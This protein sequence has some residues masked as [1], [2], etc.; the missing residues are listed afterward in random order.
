MPPE[1]GVMAVVRIWENREQKGQ[2]V[3]D[4]AGTIGACH[5]AGSIATELW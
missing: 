5:H 1:M 4:T 2:L 3:N